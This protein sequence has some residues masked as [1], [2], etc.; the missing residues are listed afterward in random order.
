MPG[1]ANLFFMF[2]CVARGEISRTQRNTKSVY[3]LVM[4]GVDEATER[5]AR[6]FLERIAGRYPITGARL[7]G[8]RARKTHRPDSDADLAVFI[9]G[10]PGNAKT[11]GVDMAGVAFDVMLEAGVLVSPL[12]IWETE[13]ESPEAFSNPELL[14][15]IRREGIAL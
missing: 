9:A 11:V 8:S 3:C 6:M 2:L 5:A 13:W 12:P 10:P 7:F 15:A 1:E 4:S 14:Q